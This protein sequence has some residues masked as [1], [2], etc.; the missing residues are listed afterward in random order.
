MKKLLSFL[1]AVL[2]GFSGLTLSAQTNTALVADGTVTNNYIPFYGLWGDAAQHNQ[3]IYPASMVS[4]MDG[5]EIQSM[6][7]F[8]SSMPSSTWAGHVLTIKLGTTALTTIPS[9]GLV[10]TPL[11]TVYTGAIVLSGDTMIVNFTT[12][13]TYSG[14]NLLL[15]FNSTAANY[16]ASSFYGVTASNASVSNYN[17][18]TYIQDFIPKTLFSFTGGATCLSPNNLAVSNITN[19]SAVF[20]WNQRSAGTDYYY[21]DT[22]GAD[23]DDAVW[24]AATQP[25]CTL[26]NLT[27]GTQ[28]IAY[29]KTDCGGGDASTIQSVSFYTQCDVV[30]TFPFFEG[31]EESWQPSILFGQNN[32]APQCWSIYNGGTTTSSYGDPYEYNWKQ[33]TNSGQV[34]EGNGSAVCYTDYAGAPHN[35][36]LIT[37]MMNIP[38]N[39]QVSF[40]AQNYSSGTSETD[41]ISVWISD[42]NL[43]LSAPAS[44]SLPLPGFTQL[45]QTAIPVGPFDLYEIDLT[46]YTGN[47]YIAFV[48]RDAPY[49]GWN[50]CLDNVSV[51]AIPACQRPTDLSTDSVNTDFAV[52]SWTSDAASYNVYYKL[53]DA[54]SFSVITEVTLN[55]DS[56]YVLTDL[57]PGNHYQWYVAGI[58]NDGT[59][60]PAT[61]VLDFNTECVLLS[62]LPYSVDFESNNIGANGTLPACWSK[63]GYNE[64]PYV[65]GYSSYAHNGNGSLRTNSSTPVIAVLPELD[66]TIAINTLQLS[67]WAYCYNGSQCY[68][69]VGAM[70]DPADA[71]TFTVIDSVTNVMG[72]YGEHTIN[73]TAYTGTAHAL[74]LRITCGTYNSYGG[75][76][77][78]DNLYIDD[79]TLMVLP[80]C[81]R[82]ENVTVTSTTA[83]TATLT[84]TSDESSFMV[85]Y[86]QEGTSAFVAAADN[87]INDTT[88]TVENLI[89]G[90]QYTFYVASICAD[91]TESMSI[92]TST[93]LPCVSLTTLP[94]FC[95][96]EEFQNND[97]NPLPA[98]WNRGS[99]NSSYPYIYSYDAYEGTHALYC[100]N[101]NT[102]SMPPIDIDELP[103]SDLQLSF[104]AKAPYDENAHL[105]VGVMTDPSD[106]TSFVQ[107]GDDILLGTGYTQYEIS[108]AGYQGTGN[109]ISFKFPNYSDTYLDNVT[110]DHM[111]ECLRPTITSVSPTHESATVNWTIENEASA[112]QIVITDAGA[113]PST[114]TP[115]DVTDNSYTFNNLPS[116]TFYQV[117]V[118]TDCGDSY[119]AWS[120]P[121]MFTT[122]A[123]APATV[124]YTCGF[125]DTLENNNWVLVNGYNN[126]IWYIETA[127][128]NT[129]DGSR[130]LYISSDTGA[131]N[132]YNVDGTTTVWAYR[133][134]QFGNADE[135][136]L[137]FDWNCMG[138]G[139]SDYPYDY[140]TVFIGSPVEVSAGSYVTTPSSLTNLGDFLG[141]STWNTAVITLDGSLVANS[142]QRIYFRWYNDYSSGSGHGAIVDNIAISEVSCARPASI[143][144]TTIGTTTATLTITSV[145]EGNNTWEVSLNDSTFTVTNS[146][147]ELE[148]LTPATEYQVMVRTICNN[149]DT[150]V[151]TVPISFISECTLINTVPQ[152]FDFESDLIAGGEYDPLPVC[153]NRIN[154]PESSYSE[155][156]YVTSYSGVNSSN[157]LYFYSYYPNAYGILPAIDADALNLQGLQISFYAK[158][159]NGSTNVSLE[160]GVMTD[161]TNAATFV[162]VQS[163][164]LSDDYPSDP[165]VVT[166]ANYTGNGTYIA[167]RN[168]VNGYASTSVYV[169]NITLE[170]IPTC[171]APTGV[172]ISGV[173]ENSATVAWTEN[174]GATEWTIRYYEQGD[175]E[176]ATV[177]SAG[178]NPFTITNMNPGTFYIVQV[179][180]EC[181]ANDSS[182]WATSSVFMTNCVAVTEYPYTESFESGSFGCWTEETVTGNNPW[183]ITGYYSSDGMYSVKMYYYVGSA[184]RLTSPIFDLTGVSNPTLTFSYNLQPY[185]SIV[186]TFAVYYRTSASSEW[187]RIEGYNTATSGFETDSLALP[188]PTATYQIAFMGYGVDGN[189]LYLDDINVFAGEGGDT[190][191]VTDPTV[192]TNAASAITQTTATLNA[193]IT[194]PDDVT[195]TAKG[196]EWK[197]TTGGTYTQVAG[198]GTGNTFTASL[199]N[200]NPSTNYTYKAFITF[201]GTTV[202]G[203][204]MTFTTLPQGVDPCAVPT[205]LHTTA[206]HNES[207]EIAWDNANVDGWNVQWRVSTGTW[208]SAHTTTNCYTITG[209]TGLTTYEIQV[210][211]DCGNNNLSDWSASI[212]ETTT[213][214][215]IES[216]TEN[217]VTLFPNPAREYVDIRIDG[218]VNVTNMEVFDVYGKLINTVNVIDNPTRI[219]VNGLANGMYFVRVTTD[220]GAVTKTFVKK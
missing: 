214:V 152:F 80:S 24:T 47:R 85:Y 150:S 112:W 5:G 16:S 65:Y 135:Y 22:A 175:A 93:T 29:V 185:G 130:S 50:L 63:P 219:N 194:N 64:S 88:Y 121:Y 92:T 91:E 35:D 54:D 147:V 10:I 127:Y 6:K 164:T 177:V 68:V 98:C 76:I 125:E 15:D 179:R 27:G 193:T 128:N 81:P 201:N 172:A 129:P 55:S 162:P 117:Y 94:Y 154:S 41:E 56:Q 140:M 160:V 46:G 176:N 2:I 33:S 131:T 4:E 39:M 72:S 70:T 184:S 170:V 34:H 119:S 161:P 100:Y 124:P 84:W 7:F 114:L 106:P 213:N 144:M 192:A 99:N 113:E 28:Y 36:W 12:P 89:P 43:V 73:L 13:Y 115:I 167:L 157:A 18:S 174:S 11:T 61:V 86:K 206:I 207:L 3:V 168:T 110:L 45:F 9:S 166:F 208:S 187:V 200:L 102:V 96:F 14:G 83:T 62:T 82:P 158:Q 216:F 74:A 19:N 111:P 23:L 148:N 199:T 105:K 30:N 67:F 53:A 159:P 122:L 146:V 66:P 202:Y 132:T 1:L 59:E 31:F 69:E 90:K 165:Y 190:T 143:A 120:N 183:T 178:T 142:V 107:I 103:F 153:W 118:R 195:I 71:N 188:N 151:W 212:T 156:P 40:W 180:S 87:A 26:N 8:I 17:G 49:D 173:T 109:R 138:E 101:W 182:N 163:V 32:E 60:L 198:M 215:G 123:T 137:T 210:Q 141:D 79:L 181:S 52:L 217:N 78:T 189:S 20:S 149:G 104:Y 204:E 57:L 169:D 218:D 205:G 97:D 220:K 203:D 108:L 38:N 77:A 197:A 186:D 139:T 44:D 25:T 209:L 133:D 75:Y 211:A 48:R 42:E 155:Y 116:S 58:C 37:P 21:V 145:S 51:E 191:Q 95:G 134:I 171:Q 136:T 126:N 196:F